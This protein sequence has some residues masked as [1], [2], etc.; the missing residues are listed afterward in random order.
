MNIPNIKFFS[1]K[2]IKISIGLVLKVIT[3][4]ALLITIISAT[5]NIIIYNLGY[6]ALKD[7]IR[8]NLILLASNAAATIDTEVIATITKPDDEGT[9]NYLKLQKQL[10]VIQGASKNK[11]RYVYTL[12]KSRNSF[13]Y[14]IDAS[15]LSDKKNHSSIGEKFI[16]E[17]YSYVEKA[18]SEATAELEPTTDEVYGG[19]IQTGYAPIMDSKGVTI[20][21]LAMDMDV[22]VLKEKEKDMKDARIFAVIF[23]IILAVLSGIIFSRYLTKPIIE[24]TKVTKKIAEGDFDTVVNIRRKD[25][26]GQLA[27]SFNAMTHDLK[28]SHEQLKR[29][30]LELEDKIIQRTKELSVAQKEI[31]QQEKENSDNI[32]Q[33]VEIIKADKELFEVYISEV[34]RFLDNCVPQLIS[35][36][37]R[38]DNSEIISDLY[39]VMHTIKSNSRVFSLERIAEQAHSIENIFSAIQS[40][41]CKLTDA[42]LNEA[43][44]KI[45]KL[46]E[47]IDKILGMYYKIVSG[48]TLDTGKARSRKRLQED[49]EFIK[50]KVQDFNKLDELI[51]K[52]DSMLDSNTSEEIH[53]IF[54]ET[55]A[56]LQFMCKVDMGRLFKRFTKVV[57]DLS[58]ELDKKVKLI[59]S[60]ENIII[61]KNVFDRICD[62]LIH[63]IRNSLDHGIEK[64]EDRINVDKP[65]EGTIELKTWLEDKD[66]Y[67]EVKD[68]GR[69]LDIAKIKES[70]VKKGFITTELAL[71]ISDE[72]AMNLIFLPGFST[73]ELVSDISGRGV[74]MDV[75]KSYIEDG[76]NGKVTLY[77]STGKGLRIL[78]V[79]PI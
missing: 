16:T 29:Y 54:R 35:L 10:Q 73:N 75:V 14:V 22:S 77:S 36:R 63:I 24:L 74:G 41:E 45:D 23:A 71:K 1:L 51:I 38:P 3:L 68:D 50:I 47:I 76:L 17:N 28:I 30:N 43:F 69:G 6:Q 4:I 9:E 79:I 12:A 70:A 34:K 32:N 15:P 65:E 19:L 59:S 2:N 46:N 42:L 40:G 64:P 66:L 25:E 52:A 11:I 5:S 26:F 72:D 53:N 7:E 56:H 61:D 39:R 37:G 18:F 49:I 44:E 13:T 57:K 67:V 33:M 60:G 21:V 48:M 20:G 31:M 8:G 78:L 27:V 55:K 58:S 62:P